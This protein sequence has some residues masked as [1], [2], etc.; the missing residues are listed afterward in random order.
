MIRNS[1]TKKL[2][3]AERGQIVALSDTDFSQKR[4]ANQLVICRKTMQRWQERYD[5]FYRVIMLHDVVTSNRIYYLL[6]ELLN[7][8]FSDCAIRRRLRQH[9]I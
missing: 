3:E 5:I 4:I 7:L 1:S 2:S 6:S 8:D 9:G